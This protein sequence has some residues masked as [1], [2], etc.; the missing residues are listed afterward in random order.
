MT[1]SFA[2]PERGIIMASGKAIF[3]VNGNPFPSPKRGLTYIVSTNVDSGRNANGEVIG[4]KVGRDVY[5]LD[6]LEWS[7]LDADT[8]SSMLKEF[9]EFF[10]TLTFWDM[11]NNEWKSLKAY[12]GDRS[13]KPMWVS[14]DGAHDDDVTDLHPVAYTECK[15]NLIDCGLLE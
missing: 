5:K 11:V 14:G 6:S 13:A 8:W 7:Y 3:F 10:V 1:S 9:S 12:P 2:L 15:V 4:Q